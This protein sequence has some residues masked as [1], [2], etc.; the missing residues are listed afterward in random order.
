[1]EGK[2]VSRI[3]L[4][5]TGRMTGAVGLLADGALALALFASTV[6]RACAA[7]PAPIDWPHST[8]WVLTCGS[9]ATRAES[10]ARAACASS[11]M[12]GCVARPR[13]VQKPRYESAKIVYLVPFGDSLVPSSF[14]VG[15]ALV[16][17]CRDLRMAEK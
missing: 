6:A 1:M 16:L 17:A 15:P 12:P 11:S 3:R 4:W 2:G 13:D 7:T 9:R 8:S 10:H 5:I 14:Q